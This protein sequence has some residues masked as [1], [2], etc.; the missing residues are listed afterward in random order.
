VPDTFYYGGQAVIEGVMIRGKK[1]MAIA[2]RRPDKGITVASQPLS[3]LYTGRWRR[4]PFLR[5]IIV[6]IETMVLGIRALMFSANVVAGEGEEIPRGVMWGTVIF[7][8]VFVVALFFL[9]PLFASRLFEPYLSPLLANIAEGVLRLAIF[10]AYL[11]LIS[12]TRDIRRVFAYHG[13]E[14]KAIN[15]Y[16]AGIPLEVAA[17]QKYS[18]VHTRCG[19]GFLL[20]VLVVAVFLFSLLGRPSLWLMVTS[21]VVLIPALAAI[22]YELMR[23]SARYAHRPGVRAMLAPGLALQSLTTRQPSP[24]QL[25]VALAALKRSLEEDGAAESPQATSSAESSL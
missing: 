15:A 20:I 10:L 19:T 16:E 24:D 4:L 12:L 22:S 17:I 25:E 7:A 3:P 21:R 11:L 9:T 6:L 14:H 1:S 13:A 18:T 8:L 2:V 5:G 23:L